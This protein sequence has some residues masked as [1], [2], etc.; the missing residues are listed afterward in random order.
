MFANSI[1]RGIP[2]ITGKFPLERNTGNRKQGLG[3]ARSGTRTHKKTL[4]FEGP[5]EQYSEGSIQEL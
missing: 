5:L 4:S 1:P 2:I 3:R